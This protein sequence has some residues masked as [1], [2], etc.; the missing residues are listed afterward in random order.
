MRTAIELAATRRAGTRRFR[1][2][3]D[4]STAADETSYSPYLRRWLTRAA[5][6]HRELLLNIE[7]ATRLARGPVP[8]PA[9]VLGPSSASRPDRWR[10]RP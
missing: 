6:R 7:A 1:L 10:A 4:H 2:R 3:T 8:I 5:T 9:P